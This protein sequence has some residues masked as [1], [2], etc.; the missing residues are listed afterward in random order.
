[1]RAELRP[2]RGWHQTIVLD[3]DVMLL[4][5]DRQCDVVVDAPGV[6]KKHC[7]LV[8]TDGLVWFRDLI[9]T[10]G[11]MVNGVK[12]RSG[13]LLPGDRVRI[14]MIIFEVFL[15]PDSREPIP[16]ASPAPQPKAK[17]APLLEKLTF[18][19]LDEEQGSPSGQD[20]GLG[21]FEILSDHD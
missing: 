18:E 11:M 8:K 3:R 20:S 14:G 17:V 21:Q 19:P 12:A 15:G 16:A 1:M 10:N 4:G 7:L 2:R 6:S 13:A 9:S 5:R